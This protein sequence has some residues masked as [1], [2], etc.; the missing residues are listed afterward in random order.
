MR[1]DR[2]TNSDGRGKYAL[3]NLRTSQVQWGG[4][5]GEQFFVLKYKDLFVAPALFAYAKAVRDHAQSSHDENE[6]RELLEYAREIE[7]EAL[8]AEM[9]GCRIPD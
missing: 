2:N 1:L 3:I 4:D 5:G 9:V 6:R 7:A 8:K